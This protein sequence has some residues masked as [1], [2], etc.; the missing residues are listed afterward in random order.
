MEENEEKKVNTEEL[1]TEAQNTVN[2]V[3][4]TIK[5]VNIKKDTE[6]TKGFIGDVFKDPLAKIQEIAT[7][8]SSKFFKFALILVAIWV[9]ANIVKQCFEANSLWGYFNF[10]K[11]MLSILL[12]AITPILIVLIMSLIIFVMNK[13]NKK[14]LT[15]VI[16]VISVAKI[17]VIIAS[18]VNLLTVISSEIS[19]VTIPFSAFCSAISTVLTYFAAKSIIGTEKNSDF[20]KKFI[21][22]EGIYYVAYIVLNLIG[23]RI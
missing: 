1:K 17:P 4:D 22:I 21:L 13:N 11:S 8:N 5:N 9:V 14:S 12:A 3:K 23:I 20:V 15:T 2:Q 19:K 6:E 16:T 7:K 18:I 10:G